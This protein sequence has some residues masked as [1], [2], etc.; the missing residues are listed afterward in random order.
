MKK[1]LALALCLMM[2][3]MVF[4]ACKGDSGTDTPASPGESI[5]AS[6]SGAEAPTIALIYSSQTGDFWGI[7]ANGGE[8]ALE[9]LKADGKI[10]GGSY[11]LSPGNSSDV[12]QQMELIDA[13]VNEK[14]DGIVLSPSNADE[15]GT[16]ISDKM[17]NLADGGIPIIVIDRSLTVPDSF[18]CVITSVMADTWEMGQECGKLAEEALGGKGEY[19]CIGIDKANKNWEN[20][21][22]GAIDWLDK[23]APDMKRSDVGDDG[24]FWAV[25]AG[26]NA[27]IM[28]F[29]QDTLTQMDKATDVVFLTTAEDYTNEVLAAVKEVK[30]N[31][32]GKTL[33]VG[34]D[35]SET[36]YNL[37][38]NGDLYGTCGQNPYL[39]G[40]DS[41]YH[42]EQYLN[43]NKTFSELTTVDYQVVTKSTMDSADVKA[44]L[45]SM[46]IS[47]G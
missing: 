14:V 16:H 10:S 31:R 27:T 37:I 9:E 3:M 46:K 32:T 24:I 36:G 47:V 30:D 34:F 23:N 2:A 6:P 44:Y 43:E 45:E 25:P 41:A 38:M 40:Y 4:V 20:R 21:T 17:K 19:V 1:V 12:T 13:A 39:M 33:I 7:V 35:F 11:L 22:T 8:K 42:M 29:V 28:P 5:S 15:I 26:G 18:D